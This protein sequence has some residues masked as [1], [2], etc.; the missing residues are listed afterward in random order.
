MVKCHKK[1]LV[2]NFI[3]TGASFLRHL[4]LTILINR[5]LRI[6]KNKKIFRIFFNS[7]HEIENELDPK[8]LKNISVSGIKFFMYVKFVLIDVDSLFFKENLFF[9]EWKIQFFKFLNKFEKIND[10]KKYVLISNRIRKILNSKDCC[11]FYENKQKK[12]KF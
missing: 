2:E 7:E 3:L 10:Q 11:K 6:T 4:Q 1:E 9:I 12:K 5:N 8:N